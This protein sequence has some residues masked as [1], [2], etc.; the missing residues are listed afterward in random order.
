MGSVGPGGSQLFS[1][2][3]KAC[4]KT[5]F[6]GAGYTKYEHSR[7]PGRS[8]SL[9]FCFGDGIGAILFGGRLAIWISDDM[10]TSTQQPYPSE[11]VREHSN[12]VIPYHISYVLRPRRTPSRGHAVGKSKEE[13]TA[14]R[15]FLEKSGE[16]LG[17]KACMRDVHSG[18]DA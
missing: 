13:P 17:M 6:N 7:T 14:L 1:V 12:T 4:Q 11:S 8:N 16:P 15:V 2:P 5:V 9:C 10:A 3:V 18:A